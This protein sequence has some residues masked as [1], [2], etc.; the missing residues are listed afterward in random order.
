M[1]VLVCHRCRARRCVGAGWRLCCPA[2]IAAAMASVRRWSTVWAAWAAFLRSDRSARMSRSV[3]AMARA[4]RLCARTAGESSA[5]PRV[6]GE[7]GWAVLGRGMRGW[8][9]RRPRPGTRGWSAGCGSPRHSQPTRPERRSRTRQGWCS[10]SLSIQLGDGAHPRVG[11]EGI[12][13]E[14]DPDRP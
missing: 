1:C 2:L 14:S 8:R 11:G 12:L 9:A 13:Q 4:C 3:R 6:G 7:D 5:H 10:C